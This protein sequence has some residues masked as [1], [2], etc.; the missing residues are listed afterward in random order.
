MYIATY[1][2][3]LSGQS[4][5]IHVQSVYS[6]QRTLEVLRSV[7]RHPH[8]WTDGTQQPSLSC[9]LTGVSKSHHRL[10]DARQS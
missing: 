9:F 5:E 8:D 7:C 6:S 3:F 10:W 1:V 4:S 2:F